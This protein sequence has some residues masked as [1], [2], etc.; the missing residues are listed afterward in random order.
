[1]QMIFLVLGIMITIYAKN[2]KKLAYDVIL[3]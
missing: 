1:M 3:P 2:K